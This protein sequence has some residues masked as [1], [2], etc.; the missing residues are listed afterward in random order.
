MAE[1]S[2]NNKRIFKNT[3]VLYIRMI[4]VLLITLYTSRVVLKAL[5]IDDFGLFNVVG[6]VVGLLTFFSDTMSKATSRFL[7]FAMVRDNSSIGNIFAS[8]ITVHILVAI[9]FLLLGETVGLWFLNAKIHIPEGRELAAN[10]VYQSTVITFCLSIV[11]IPYRAAVVSYEKMSFIAVTGIIEAVLKLGIA[12][13]LLTSSNDRLTLYGILLL[14]VHV[15]NYG[16]YIAYCRRNYK[17][18]R[19]RVSFDKNN[20]K[21]IFSFV[22]WALLG[23]FAVVGCNQGNVVLVNL[24]HSVAANAAMSV[25]NQ[26]SHAITNLTTNFQ[27]AFNPQITKSYAAED[28]NYLKSLTYT[29]SKISFCILFVVIL[30]VAFNIDWVLDIWLDRVPMYSNI[31]AILFMVNGVMNALSAPFHFVALATGNIRNFQIATALVFLLDIPIVYLLFSMGLPPVTVMWVKIG[32]ITCILLV[33]IYYASKAV[34]AIRFGSYLK[35][36]LLPL[37]GTAAVMTSSAIILNDLVSTLG[38]RLLLTVV[39]EA[40]SFILLYY[41]CLKKRERELLLGYIRRKKQ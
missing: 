39:I 2:A 4:V 32:V 16:L 34:P 33:R 22:S 37:F 24:F 26:I 13:L 11:T 20:L 40:V 25:G 19:F 27:T 28:Y 7:N 21:Q 38:E 12:F 3:I 6:G 36:I 14:G 1:I 17:D 15:F 5:G 31:F 10:I 29:T 41:V 9:V 8:S 23:Q 18:L 35:T 30:P